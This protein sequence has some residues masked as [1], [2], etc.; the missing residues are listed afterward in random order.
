MQDKVF[1]GS[2]ERIGRLR[3]CLDPVK[4]ATTRCWILLPRESSGLWSATES[5]HAGFCRTY[6][7]RISQIFQERPQNTKPQFPE[8]E[9]TN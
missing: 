6:L 2:C 5:C 9:G 4:C 1:G 7:L 3:L 8:I